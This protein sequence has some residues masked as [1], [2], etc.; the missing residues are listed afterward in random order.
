MWN[1]FQLSDFEID[2]NN[3]IFKGTVS[4]IYKALDKN[5]KKEYAIK[6]ISVSVF[7]EEEIISSINDMIIM[8][9]CENS[10]KFFGYFKDDNYFYIIMELCEFSLDKIINEKKGDIKELKE[11]IEQLNNALK[12]MQDNGIIHQNI[13]P[14]N[15]LIKKSENNKNIYKLTDYRLLKIFKENNN[16]ETFEYIAPEIRNNL[17]DSKLKVDLWSI[18]IIIHK[19]YF[20]ETPKNNIIQKTKSIYLDDLI[21]NLIVEIPFD[22][23]NICRINWE[24][25]FNHIFYKK[26][27]FYLNN[28]LDKFNGTINMMI[29]FINKK[30]EE[31]KNLIHKEIENINTDEHNEKIGNFSA[32]LNEF[33]F[34][35]DKNKLSEIFRIFEKSIFN[36]KVI[37]ENKVYIDNDIIY[38]GE[39]MKGTNI[40][41]GKGVEYKIKKDNLLVFKGEYLN[42]K[43]NGKGRE[44]YDNNNLKYQGEYKEGKIWNGKGY[45]IKGKLEFEVKNG[46]GKV[47]EYKSDG[48]LLFEGEYLKGERNG[49]GKEYNNNGELLFEGEYLNGKKN[50]KAKEYY[51]NG[52]L[53]FEGEYLNDKKNGKAK[54]Y[55]N[56]NDAELRFEG[57]YKEGEK[58][59]GKS[60][61]EFKR[62]KIRRGNSYF[63]IGNI[64]FEREYLNGK[65]NL[66]VK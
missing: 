33:S 27:I 31:F 23:N 4:S 24:D 32:L 61:W 49:N 22:K 63:Y 25:Y 21:Q 29:S 13:K 34:N 30:Y 64:I 11:I 1:N 65:E 41:N 18:G 42:G 10:T 26:E 14:E 60:Y 53:K 39:T 9:E 17:N 55:G 43:R 40:K 12:I 58:W 2:F 38:E 47:K 15:I 57:F 19:L 44:Y 7:K 51:Y 66:T 6:R 37:V 54:E 46:N 5:K 56:I 3:P 59:N 48:K 50:G 45:D 35:E 16:K 8:N 36:D 62:R 28:S 52:K 20:G